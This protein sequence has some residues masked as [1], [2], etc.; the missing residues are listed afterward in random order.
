MDHKTTISNDGK[1]VLQTILNRRSIRNYIPN[2][3]IPQD[4]LYELIKAGMAAPTAKNRQPWAFI[5][6]TD[7]NILKKLGNILPHGKMLAEAGGAI[8]VCGDMTQTLEGAGGDFWIQDCA[9]ASENIMIASQAFGLGAVWVGIYPNKFIG[10]ENVIKMNKVL[11]LPGSVIALNVISLGYP[12]S[13]E[14]PKDKYDE[15]KIHLNSWK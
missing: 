12:D 3:P 11:N 1:I 8:V 10:V 4:V 13:D 5:A 9:A 7:S 14:K 2:K 6:I 15:S